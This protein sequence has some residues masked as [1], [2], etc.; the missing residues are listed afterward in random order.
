MYTYFLGIYLRIDNT[1]GPS[2][3]RQIYEYM[4]KPEGCDL[5]SA[6]EKLRE[7]MFTLQKGGVRACRPSYFVHSFM[8]LLLFNFL[9]CVCAVVM[10]D[11]ALGDEVLVQAGFSG[12]PAD[13]IQAIYACNSKGNA[14][15]LPVYV[16]LLCAEVILMDLFATLSACAS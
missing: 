4:L 10:Y 12:F 7:D 3:Q 16:Y 13:H 5:Y 2:S 6:L 15:L 8:I 11:A 1:K 14:A 9:C